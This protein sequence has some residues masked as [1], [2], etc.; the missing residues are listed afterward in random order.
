M[1]DIDR[2]YHKIK[3]RYSI[4]RTQVDATVKELEFL[5]QLLDMMEDD[6]FGKDNNVPCSGWISVKDRLPEIDEDVLIL[7][8]SKV[9]RKIG[10][11]ITFLKD[12]FYFGSTLIPYQTPQ[13]NEPWQ[14]FRENNSITHW[15]PLPEPPKEGDSE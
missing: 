5:V 10:Y 7:Y 8:E 12:S 13:W 11:A 9:L 14:Y 4:R 1:T 6:D 15:M 2:L 3:D